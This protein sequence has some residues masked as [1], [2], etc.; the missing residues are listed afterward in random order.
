HRA[1]S[2]DEELNAN[3]AWWDERAA[4]HGQDGF[5][6][7]IEA[8]LAGEP[9]ITRR[10]VSELEAALGSLDG[11]DLLHVQCH[12]GLGTLSLAQLGARV[13]GLDFSSVAIDRARALAHEVGLDASFVVAD[14]QRLPEDLRGRFDCVFA[15]HG[16]L[17]WIADVDAWMSSAASALRPGGHLV[18]VDGHPISIVVRSV[19]PLVLEP[20][21]QG[22][23]VLE[24]DF[25]D[26]AHPGAETTNNRAFH[27]R[28]SIGDVVTAAARAGLRVD[29]L[30]E[31]TDDEVGAP[32]SPKLTRG[33]DG[34]FQL[35]LG[36]ADLPLLYGLQ[37]TKA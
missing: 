10:E 33:D 13:T 27:Y 21:Y 18:L 3:R 1:R 6:Y 28:W 12:L 7:D 4:L 26:Y 30:T 34:L 2:M 32:E 8:F 29:A 36:D 35:R 23:G 22:G 20:P 16:V 14:A 19:D 9:A 24:R 11:V 17:M 15:S 25:A 5:F 37:A 31:W